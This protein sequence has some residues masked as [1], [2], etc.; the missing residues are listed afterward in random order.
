MECCLI[1]DYSFIFMAIAID[2]KKGAISF[3]MAP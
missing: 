3:E 1:F 2:I